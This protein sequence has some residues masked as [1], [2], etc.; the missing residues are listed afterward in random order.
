MTSAFMS[1]ILTSNGCDDYI[2]IF[3]GHTGVFVDT[4]Q[5]NCDFIHIIAVVEEYKVSQMISVTAIPETGQKD[6]DVYC[7]HK[8][9]LIL[10]F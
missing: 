3:F 6:N 5:L 1:E 9:T 10:I 7:V 4:I 8:F 2:T